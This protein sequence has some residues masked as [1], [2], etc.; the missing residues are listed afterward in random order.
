MKSCAECGSQLPIGTAK[1]CFNCRKGLWAAA[2]AT[3]DTNDDDAVIQSK[4]NTV[5][6]HDSFK[7]TQQGEVRGEFQEQTIHSLGIKLE[8]TVEL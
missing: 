2:A 3:S 4:E 6:S 1:F 8:E 7:A 5:S